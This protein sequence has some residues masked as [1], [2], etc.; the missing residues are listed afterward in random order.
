[1]WQVHKDDIGMVGGRGVELNYHTL[2]LH[3][4][5]TII[6]TRTTCIHITYY[7]IIPMYIT[8][9]CTYTC[10]YILHL[11][12]ALYTNVNGRISIMSTYLHLHYKFQNVYILHI[13]S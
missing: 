11:I 8:I 9:L 12:E 13:F 4:Y 6:L 2:R 3:Y 7:Y 10:V 1:M 5:Y